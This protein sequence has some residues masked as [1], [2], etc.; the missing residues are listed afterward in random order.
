MANKDERQL[1]KHS[2]RAEIDRFLHKVAATPTPRPA[3]QCGRLL[4]AMDATA[5]REPTWNR[6]CQIQGEMFVQTAALGG[7]DV[8]LC[9]YRGLN[10]FHSSAWLNGPEALIQRMQSVSCLGGYTQLIRVLQHARD[11]TRKRKVDT[12]VFIGD[13]MEED[14]DQLRHLAGELGI[15]GVPA[16]VF[17]EGVDPVAENAFRQLAKLTGG[18]YYRF[19]ATSAQQLRELLGAVAVYAAGGH[20]A[21][22][23]YGRR[24]GGVAPRLMDQ[25]KRG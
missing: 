3:D 13:C 8:Q 6:A 18:A 4:F 12:L 11:E 21:L 14:V 10:E 7:L 5:S 9:Y 16:F 2:G 19:D 23:D 20:R 15:L 1:P 22:E 24:R 25:L 17:Q